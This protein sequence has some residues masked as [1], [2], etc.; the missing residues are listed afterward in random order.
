MLDFIRDEGGSTSLENMLWI[1]LFVL[2]VSAACIALKDAV[3]Q[4]AQN[5]AQQI[6]ETN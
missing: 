4:L 5:T 6:G 2:G 3:V 1:V